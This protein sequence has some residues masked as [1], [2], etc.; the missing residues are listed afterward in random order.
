MQ[1]RSP[2]TGSTLTPGVWF[3]KTAIL[4]GL[5]VED[6]RCGGSAHVLEF[7]QLKLC[8]LWFTAKRKRGE[9]SA[10]VEGKEG[11][12]SA[13][14]RRSDPGTSSSTCSHQPKPDQSESEYFPFIIPEH[15]SVLRV[16]LLWFLTM[17]SRFL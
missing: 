16:H 6:L 14:S 3:I 17:L 4:L 10:K 7:K 15:C 13:R 8:L 9:P 2:L 12:E 5:L 1:V 11:K